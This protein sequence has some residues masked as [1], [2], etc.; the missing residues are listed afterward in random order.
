MGTSLVLLNLAGGKCVWGLR[1]LEKDEGLGRVLR[2]AEA[3]GMGRP[4][5]RGLPG[6]WRKERRRSVPS[7]SAVFRFLN[8]FHDEEE[9]SRRQAHTA[10]IPAAT[11][12]LLGLGPGQRRLGGL[13]PTPGSA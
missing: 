10:F 5:R 4:E 9:E 6:R 1:L 3:H 11:A 8:R 7:V 12:G 13:R 2:L